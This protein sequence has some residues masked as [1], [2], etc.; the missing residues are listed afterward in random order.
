MHGNPKSICKTNGKHKES[1]WLTL[2][3]KHLSLI[4]MEPLKKKEKR[5]AIYSLYDM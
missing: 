4:E 1:I 2:L 3:W 5:C